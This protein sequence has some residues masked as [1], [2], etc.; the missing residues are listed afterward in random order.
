MAK[1]TPAKTPEGKPLPIDLHVGAR[2]RE[3]RIS[4]GMGQESLA[5]LTGCTFQQIQKYEKGVN[6][7][8]CS[9]LVQIADALVV[10]PAYFFEG[11]GDAKKSAPTPAEGIAA[12]LDR[13]SPQN[14]AAIL[15]IVDAALGIE[16]GA[17]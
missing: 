11:L 8:S 5:R 9:R 10:A 13:L 16:G 2:I 1:R 12:L 3:L 15:S 14:R 7:V 4:R 17:Q 6:R